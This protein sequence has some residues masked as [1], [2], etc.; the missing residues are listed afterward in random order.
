MSG[1]GKRPAPPRPRA[2]R[3]AGKG[4]EA[5]AGAA[6]SRPPEKNAPPGRNAASG[7]SGAPA[8]N[9]ATGKSTAPGQHPTSGKSRP[10]G[11][12]RPGGQPPADRRTAPRG[13]KPA[14]PRPPLPRAEMH[15]R[16][17]HLAGYDFTALVAVAPGLTKHLITTPAGTQSI[18]FANPAAVKA[19]NR[20]LLALDYGIKAWDIPAGYLCPP[21]PGR[22]D[23][24]HHLAD[25]L[26]NG[27]ESTIP[28][29]PSIRVLDIGV[30]A[31]CVYPLVGHAEYGWRFLGV[32]ID[33]AALANA[34]RILAANALEGAIELREQPVPENI[35]VGLLRSG[36]KFDLSLCNPPFHDSPGEAQAGARRKWNQLGKPQ[37]AKGPQGPHLN[38]GGQDTELWSP[39][40]E[41]AFLETMVAQS[42]GIPKRCLWFTSLVA[43]ADNLE[44]VEAALAK[45]HPADVRIVP[46]AQGQKQSRLVA[47]TFI[48]RAERQRWRQE[49]NDRA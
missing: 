4:G 19:L 12:S 47:W 36:E 6:R 43:K 2:E 44:H 22:A 46:M 48:G 30:G 20:A 41:R 1:P 31:N 16:N 28:T 39:G 42:A 3:D 26:A 14:A 5:K 18:D 17:R 15:P 25:L 37:A 24:L 34:R 45:V 9:P 33:P 11:P 13:E 7:K 38:F 32:D 29:G 21:I 35:F 8:K 40:G 10:P 23:Y 49:R 27:D